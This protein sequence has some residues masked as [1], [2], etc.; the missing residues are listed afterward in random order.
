[1]MVVISGIFPYLLKR[2]A[3]SHPKFIV[4]GAIG[5]VK[6]SETPPFDFI[7]WLGQDY[8]QAQTRY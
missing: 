2:P 4:S 8:D 1:M 6:T 7:Q 3:L 5:Q